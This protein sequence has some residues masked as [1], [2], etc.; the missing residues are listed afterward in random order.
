M[1]CLSAREAYLNATQTSYDISCTNDA[2]IVAA[3]IHNAP[4]GTNG[5]IV[6]FFD[7]ATAFSG[8]VSESSLAQQQID[9][10]SID[11]VSFEEFL[12][13]LTTGNL[14]VNVHTPTN[15]GG[16]LRGQ[17]PSPPHSL[18]FSQFGNG[19]GSGLTMTS[20]IV[21][22]NFSTTGD[23]ITASVNLLDPDGDP[24]DVGFVGGTN[25]VTI[26]PMSA[27][28][29]RTDGM[30]DL[31][32]GSASA[33]ATGPLAGVIRF[34]ILPGFG[35]AGVPASTPL[36]SALVPVRNLGTVRTTLAIRNTYKNEITVTVE[37]W[38]DV[39]LTQKVHETTTMMIPAGGRIAS[40]VDEI[41]PALAGTEFNGTATLKVD[42]GSFAAVGL[43]Q[44]PGVFTT[45]PVTPLQ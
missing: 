22:I 24:L 25:E 27:A 26:D 32:V 14:Y 34:A 43:E 11:P 19:S 20:D 44:G 28:T 4:A 16:E 35:V 36:T 39:G 38:V 3:H 21:L 10:Q 40:F 29:L 15:P 45:L 41:F 13:L 5:P 18:F 42:E 2:D 7:A 8:V 6:F 33:T 23:P 12:S 37:V 30:G 31:V 17:I 9:H 1:A